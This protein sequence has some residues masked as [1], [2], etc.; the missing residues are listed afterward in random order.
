[1]EIPIEAPNEVKRRIARKIEENG[2]LKRVERKIKMGMMIAVQELRENP[3]SHG[4]LERKPFKDANPYELKALQ[5]IFNFLSDHNM[6]YTLSTLLEESGVKRI[7]SD[8][9]DI[10]KIIEQALNLGKIDYVDDSDEPIHSYSP[11]KQKR[12]QQY[13]KSPPKNKRY[14]DFENEYSFSNENT[15]VHPLSKPNQNFSGFP[16]SRN[17]FEKNNF[18]ISV[19]NL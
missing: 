2:V 12:K 7:N 10:T 5:A 1:M 15:S 8:S 17:V 6:S 3:Q 18:I 14:D 13:T 19:V 11:Y 16:I 4:N 9:T